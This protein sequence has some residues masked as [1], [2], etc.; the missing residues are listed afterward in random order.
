MEDPGAATPYAELN[1]F[2]MW[3]QRATWAE[4]S[5][6]LPVL[7]TVTMSKN[8]VLNQRLT[9]HLQI[10]SKEENINAE[11]FKGYRASVLWDDKSLG[12]YLQDNANVLNNPEGES[13]SVVSDSLWP[14]GQYSPWNS[15]GQNTGVSSH[16]LL[17]GIFPTQESNPGLLHCRQILDHLSHQGS[18][19]KLE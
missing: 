16:S 9:D 3:L 19:S 5:G 1:L 14:R 8:Q 18:P 15:P 6:G 4:T 11:L 10:A 7:G 17:Q 2:A 12:D 13:H